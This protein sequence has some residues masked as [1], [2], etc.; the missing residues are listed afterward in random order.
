MAGFPDMVVELVS[1][2]FEG[3]TARFDWRWTGTNRGPGGTGRA[4]DMTGYEVWSFGPNGLIA[5]S[6]G[7]LDQAEYDRQMEV[8]D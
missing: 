7:H 5:R 2:K 3:D 1:V 4:V 6:Q 8:D